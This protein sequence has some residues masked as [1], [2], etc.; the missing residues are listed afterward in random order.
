MKIKFILILAV[1]FGVVACGENSGTST[2]PMDF[3]K[4]NETEKEE[5]TDPELSKDLGKMPSKKEFYRKMLITFCKKNF[6][7]KFKKEFDG[8]GLLVKKIEPIN[9]NTVTAIGLY[10]YKKENTHYKATIT[11]VAKETYRIT[12]EIEIN[13]PH[14]EKKRWDDTTDT[15]TYKE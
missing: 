12:F 15:I 5:T 4:Q 9:D 14:C 8:K 3:I 11:R 13:F 2:S 7:K 10:T 1:L 6:N